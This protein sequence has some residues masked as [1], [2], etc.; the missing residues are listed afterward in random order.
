MKK[1]I[2]IQL[3]GHMRTFEQCAPMLLKNVVEPNKD[4]GYVI[5]IFIHTWDESDHNTISWRNDGDGADVCDTQLQ[6]IMNTY[7]PVDIQIT[8][9]VDVPEYIINEKL[10]N[11]RSIRGPVNMS[12]SL[13]Q[14]SRLRQKSKCEYDW[15]IVTRPDVL[16]LSPFR[17]N[18]FLKVYN[19]FGIDIPDGAIFYAHNPYRSVFKVGD[20]RIIAAA[21]CIWFGRPKD[22]DVATLLY[23]NFDD[24][25]DVDNFYCMEHWVMSWLYKCGLNPIPLKYHYNQDWV[26]LYQKDVN[27]IEKFLYPD[28]RKYNILNMCILKTQTVNIKK[29]FY[30][31]NVFPV[32]TIKK[33]PN[34]W[35][36]RLFDII[37]VGFHRVKK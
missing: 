28:G 7:T 36:Y 24:S 13:S 2:A 34:L 4:D 11:R 8:P 17:I 33:K 29:T 6:K 22:I 21:D 35:I 14:S 16:F 30:V 19:H 12:F 25:I 3:F 27:L 37:P 1:R 31:F 32:L 15:V 9:Q 5:D 18:D 23:D 20:P 10:G 26:I